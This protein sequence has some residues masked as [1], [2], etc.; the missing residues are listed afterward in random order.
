LIDELQRAGLVPVAT[1]DLLSP[2]AALSTALSLALAYGLNMV[3]DR[4]LIRR[5]V[6]WLGSVWCRLAH[7]PWFEQM[8]LYRGAIRCARC[9]RVYWRELKE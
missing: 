1:G 6:S 4:K 5:A 2:L 3:I 8:V 7:F 9:E